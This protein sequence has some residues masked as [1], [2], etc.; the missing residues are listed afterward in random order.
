MRYIAGYDRDFA[1]QFFR[2]SV[3]PFLRTGRFVAIQEREV[4][5]LSVRFAETATLSLTNPLAF[6]A[7]FRGSIEELASSS[8]TT[9]DPRLIR[10]AEWAAN[11]LLLTEGFSAFG[12]LRKLRHDPQT[13]ELIPLRPMKPHIESLYSSS[14]RG[15]FRSR[16]EIS[17]L[18]QL[19]RHV[20]IWLKLLGAIPGNDG[21][22]LATRRR[23]FLFTLPE[24]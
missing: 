8:S 16:E 21:T 5:Y 17:L 13:G 2:R 7:H 10:L 1:Q 24:E 19:A 11:L 18:H 22:D 20:D 9:R 3:S 23:S 15:R 14:A 12:G 4:A 6:P